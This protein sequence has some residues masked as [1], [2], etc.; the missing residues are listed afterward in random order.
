[1]NK[2]KS[3]KEVADE[4]LDLDGPAAILGEEWLRPAEGHG[5]VI[6][7]PSYGLRGWCVNLQ[8]RR[9]A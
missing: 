5:S 3:V 8:H 6:S 2:P 4:L 9:H 1:M 7:P